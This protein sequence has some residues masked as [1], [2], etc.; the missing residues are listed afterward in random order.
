MKSFLL[1][2][3]KKLRFTILKIIELSFIIFLLEEKKQKVVWT[4]I[5]GKKLLITMRQIEMT[6]KKK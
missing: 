1:N 6:I 3:V 4:V 2:Q 5:L